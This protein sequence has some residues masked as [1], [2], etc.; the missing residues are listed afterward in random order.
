MKYFIQILLLC[1][2]SGQGNKLFAQDGTITLRSE[3][4]TMT[5]PK[6]VHKIMEEK[7]R[8][9]KEKEI[10]R[11]EFCQGVRAQVFYG[12]DR[13]EAEKALNEAKE[14]FPEMYSNLEYESPDYKVKVGFFDSTN[15]AQ[16]F[17]RTAKKE[18][19]LSLPV[20]EIIRCGFLD[21]TTR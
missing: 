5:M 2:L 19:P 17:L 1:L 21:Q 9:P 4:I 18:F 8:A 10:P 15:S 14:L 11:P 16:P 20:T 13:N 3:N 12:K 7:S 6:E